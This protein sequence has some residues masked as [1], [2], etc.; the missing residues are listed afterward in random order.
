[1]GCIRGVQTSSHGSIEADVTI[2]CLNIWTASTLGSWLR[3]LGVTRDL[4]VRIEKHDLIAVRASQQPYT[5]TNSVM[6]PNVRDLIS[7]SK[8]YFRAYDGGASLLVGN[9]HHDMTCKIA[10]ENTEQWDE[11]VDLDMQLHCAELASARFTGYE[12]AEVSSSWSGC[13]DVSPD[14]NPVMG[15]IPEMKGLRVAFGFSGHGFKLCPVVGA[16]LA[17]D[18]LNTPVSSVLDGPKM[19]NSGGAEVGIDVYSITRFGNGCELTGVYG[20]TA[21]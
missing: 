1:M 16:L 4:P 11:S 20:G 19:I 5:G 15:P 6:L 7:P 9:N 12:H 2:S 21:A 17:A 13:Y 3:A 8:P 10:D 14:W 18:A